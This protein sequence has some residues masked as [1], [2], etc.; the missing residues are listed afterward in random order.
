[1]AG[2]FLPCIGF[3]PGDFSLGKVVKSHFFLQLG[4]FLIEE[5]NS[6]SLEGR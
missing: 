2:E 5:F 6:I 1:M 4:Q 3:E